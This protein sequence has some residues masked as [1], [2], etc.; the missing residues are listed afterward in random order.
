MSV[1]P[2][3]YYKW[4]KRKDIPNRYEQDRIL[5]TKLLSEQ[6]NKHPSHGYHML[7][8][9]VFEDTGWVFSHNLAHKCCK[10]AGIHSKARKYT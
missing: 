5:L 6:H 8:K 7:A 4:R 2:S 3:G 10:Y 9:A 1:N